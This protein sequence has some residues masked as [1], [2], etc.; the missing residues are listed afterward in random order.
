MEYPNSD[1]PLSRYQSYIRAAHEIR[2]AEFLRF[3][4]VVRRGIGKA[5]RN[6]LSPLAWLGR[7]LDRSIRLHAARRELEAMDD[8]MLAD[9]GIGRDEI[10]EVVRSGKRQKLPQRPATHPYEV[11]RAAEVVELRR[12]PGLMG[13]LILH[14]PWARYSDRGR[15]HNDAA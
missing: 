3:A 7:R 13:A 6:L 8:R 4:G 14:G 1:Q 10:R 5:V 11:K 2:S 9:L 12:E 15:K